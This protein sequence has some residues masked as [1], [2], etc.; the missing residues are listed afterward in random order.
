MSN[1][2]GLKALIQDKKCLTMVGAHNSF[3]AKL[4]E[5]AGFDGVYISGAGLSGNWGV[6]DT[7]ILQLS[8]FAYAANFISKATSLPTISDADTG[9]GDVAKTVRDYI[10]AGISG[11]HIED[12]VFP[13]RCG[14]LKGKEVIP[15]NEMILKIKEAVRTRNEIDPD[16]MIIARCDARGASNVADK[17][18]FDESVERGKA[19]IEA[20]ADV[21][22]PESLRDRDEFKRYRKGVDCPL[23]ANMTEFGNTPYITYREFADMGYNIVIFP[24]TMFRYLAGR[25][26]HALQ[27]LKEAG[28]QESLLPEMLS[29]QE[30]N[31]ILNYEP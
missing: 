16:F 24:V 22:F 5:R 13:K 1:H 10:K 30:I 14:H 9:F 15:A 2:R 27:I 12:Q 29:R 31:K 18:Q 3:V 11:L 19:Y 21:I 7:G 6:T 23:L 28:H 20:G 4:V 25:A 26:A 17:M 8:D